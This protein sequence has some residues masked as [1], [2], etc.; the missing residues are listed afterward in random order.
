MRD[1]YEAAIGNKVKCRLFTM[2]RSINNE[3]CCEI[4]VLL[5]LHSEFSIVKKNYS[6][7][8][9]EPCEL[10]SEEPVTMNSKTTYMLK[11]YGKYCSVDDKSS[12]PIQYQKNKHKSQTFVIRPKEDPLVILLCFKR[13]VPKKHENL[14]YV[15]LS[16][17]A[18]KLYAYI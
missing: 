1:L 2:T 16:Q 8:G 11:L 7:Q 5:C 15:C 12:V 13:H 3:A 9:Y 4:L 18:F 6:N 14:P 10:E 17:H